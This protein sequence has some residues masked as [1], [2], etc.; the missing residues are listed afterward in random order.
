[1]NYKPNTIDW[2]KGDMVIHDADAKKNYMLMR[3]IKVQKN[4]LV[5]TEYI[6]KNI[7]I[8]SGKRFKNDKKFLHLPDRFGIET[9]NSKAIDING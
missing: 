4:G 5:V 3:V 7:N 2:E 6:D 1:M 9:K 8:L